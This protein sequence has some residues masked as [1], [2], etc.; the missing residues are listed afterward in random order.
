[1]KNLV[2]NVLFPFVLLFFSNQTTLAQVYFNPDA[3]TASRENNFY[4]GIA[5][6]VESFTGMIGLSLEAKV[7]KH[8]ALYAGAGV[9][10]W[11]YKVSGGVKLYKGFPYRWAYCGSFSYASGLKDFKVRMET[12]SGSREVLMDLLPCQTFNLSAQHH[13]KIG[14]GS[15]RF[16]I[17]FGLSFPF[18]KNAYTIKD[19]SVLTSES[20]MVMKILQPGRLMAGIGFSFGK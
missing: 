15:N 18:T 6:G 1:M 9:G 7:A 16:N 3:L 5:S 11:G 20:T 13:W 12:A 2:R 10:G 14:N 4:I 19:G 17:E 8:F